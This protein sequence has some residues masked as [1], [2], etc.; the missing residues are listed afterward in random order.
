MQFA[1]TV[2]GFPDLTD[3]EICLYAGINESEINKAS[4]A[5][6]RQEGKR[7]T[8]YPDWHAQH[9]ENRDGHRKNR[10]HRDARRQIGS[11]LQ[12][13]PFGAPYSTRPTKFR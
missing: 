9:D 10:G 5:T 3:G 13:Q 11:R 1:I 8:D 7:G 12:N 6:L 2:A 4:A